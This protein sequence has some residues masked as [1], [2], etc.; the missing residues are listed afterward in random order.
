LRKKTPISRKLSNSIIIISIGILLGLL[1]PL[2]SGEIGNIG[3][4]LNGVIIGFLGA[5]FIVMSEIWYSRPI[6]RQLRFSSLV[7]YKSIVYSI[8]FISLIIIVLTIERAH[9]GKVNVFSFIGSNTFN[10][11]VFGDDLHIIILYALVST[12]SFIFVYQISRK[13]GQGVLWNFIIGKYHRAREEERIFMFMD[14]NDST[15]LAEN[16]GDIEYN[17][18]LNDFFFDITDSILTN[19]GEI[20]RYV[21]DEI[22]VSWKLRRGL[23]QASFLRAFFQAKKAIHAKREK[24]LNSYGVVPKFTGGF[25]YGKVIIGEIGEV[26]SQISF[27]GDVMYETTEIEKAC[28]TYGADV[29]VAE[30]LL[31]M[32]EL[33]QIYRIR[34]AGVVDIPELS[35]I[36]VFSVTEK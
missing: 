4:M 35:A 5:S 17:K 27:F 3:R 12:T 23:A 25:N 11:S 32:V 18:L 30:G 29:L 15:K 7:I 13:M 1:Y 6:I 2:L 9:E 8:F 33:P 22:V 26:K 20:Y 19:Y 21:G 31:N 34:E 16:L 14:I 24:Y 36:K 10:E 28:K